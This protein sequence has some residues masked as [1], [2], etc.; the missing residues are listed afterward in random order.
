MKEEM[1]IKMIFNV[2]NA[3][4]GL[5]IAVFIPLFIG[6]FYWIYKE[7]V[8]E[9]NYILSIVYIILFAVF[10]AGGFLL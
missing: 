4:F 1:D 8:D 2:T 3:I 7:I 10:I 5:I 6:L 9:R